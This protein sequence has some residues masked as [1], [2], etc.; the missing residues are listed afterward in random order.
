MPCSLARTHLPFLLGTSIG[1]SILV[2][3]GARVAVTGHMRQI[4]RRRVTG[5]VWSAGVTT[6]CMS[7]TSLM[8]PMT[9][10]APALGLTGSM[11]TQEL[12]TT[13]RLRHTGLV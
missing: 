5:R 1:W 11:S 10:H 13:A 8:L 7:F 3:V 12:L 4:I 9:V 2:T 6:S